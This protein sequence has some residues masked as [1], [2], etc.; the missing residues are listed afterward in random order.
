LAVADHFNAQVAIQA[1]VESYRRRADL[2]RKG[3]PGQSRG[4][5]I[6]AAA[7]LGVQP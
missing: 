5:S 3:G 6:L 4:F 2:D 1:N 7:A